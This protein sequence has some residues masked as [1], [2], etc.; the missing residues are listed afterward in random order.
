MLTLKNCE[1][2]AGVTSAAS[3]ASGAP[4]HD[5][6]LS[7]KTAQQQRNLSANVCGKI[8]LKNSLFARQIH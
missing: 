4:A 6:K 3:R 8:E 1:L 7:N 2:R 5:L